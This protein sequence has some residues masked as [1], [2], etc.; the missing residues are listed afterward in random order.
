VLSEEFPFVTAIL[1]SELPNW[2]EVAPLGLRMTWI[3]SGDFQMG[4]DS[5]ST[6]RGPSASQATPTIISDGFWMSTT[7]VTEFQYHRAEKGDLSWLLKE[8][9]VAR[10]A[11]NDLPIA[12]VSWMDATNFCHKMTIAL[13]N[14]GSLYEGFTVRLPSEAEWEWACRRGHPT[15]FA[16]GDSPGIQFED[17]ARYRDNG[18][19]SSGPVGEKGSGQSGLKGMYGNVKEWCLDWKYT[20]TGNPQTNPIGELTEF[21]NREKTI[22]GGDYLSEETMCTGTARTFAIPE[23]KSKQVGFRIVLG[24]SSSSKPS[25]NPSTTKD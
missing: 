1:D 2:F 20:Y 13:K 6:P 9:T 24:R 4:E 7:E 18:K 3:P 16:F 17:R 19:N 10:D 23:F 21:S 14:A 15:L 12:N 25:P 5:P 11:S 22:R 8:E